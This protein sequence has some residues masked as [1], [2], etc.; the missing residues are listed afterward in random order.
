MLIL[1][2]PRKVVEVSP[3]PPFERGAEEEKL[4]EKVQSF[5]STNYLD[6]ILE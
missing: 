3:Q 2:T 6:S 5:L 4:T 1:S